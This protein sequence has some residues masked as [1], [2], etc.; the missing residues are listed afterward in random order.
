[1]L[2]RSHCGFAIFNECDPSTCKRECFTA[3]AIDINRRHTVEPIVGT[4]T[5]LVILAISVAALAWCAAEGLGRAET[6][7]QQD[8]RI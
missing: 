1:M 5:L 6:E 7:F 2:D 3:R 4:K 8:A